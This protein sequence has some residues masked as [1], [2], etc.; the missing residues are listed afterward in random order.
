MPARDIPD[1]SGTSLQCSYVESRRPDKPAATSTLRIRRFSV[2]HN[3]GSRTHT[4]VGVH[5][6]LK[7]GDPNGLWDSL[8]VDRASQKIDGNNPQV[9]VRALTICCDT[10][11]VCGEFSL[12][13]AD[14]AVFARRLLWADDAAAINTSPLPWTMD[15]ARNAAGS[16]AGDS[17]ANGRKAGALRIFLKQGPA[18]GPARPRLIAAGGRGQDPGAGQD[19]TD[20]GWMNAY[21]KYPF[22]IRDS[23]MSTSKRTVDFSPVAVFVEYEWRWAAS[24]VWGPGT[25]GEKRFPADGTHALAP[26]KPG[27]GGDGGGLTTNQSGLPALFYNP[28]GAAG[29]QERNYRGGSAGQPAECAHYNV[30]LWENLFGTDNASFE[31]NLTE[32]RTAQKGNDAT[33]PGA[34]RALGATP[35]PTVLVMPNGWL[36]PLGLQATLEFARDLFLAGARDDVAALLADYAEGLAGEAPANGAWDTAPASQWTAAQSEVAAML[37]RLA[38]QLDY[39]GHPAGYTPLLSLPGAI[40]LYADETRRAL[41]MMLV[42]RWVSDASRDAKESADSL[43][44]ALD[45]TIADS[46]A[47]TEQVVAGE[48]RIDQVRSLIN[49][50]EK[51]LNDLSNR[52]VVLRNDL[53]VKVI[54]DKERQKAIKFSIKMAGALCQVIPVGQPALGTVGSLASVAADFVGGDP[55]DVPDTVSKMGGVLKKANEAAEK[56]KEASKKAAEKKDAP[57]A[58]NAAGAKEQSSAWATVGK[59]LGPALEITAGALKSLQVPKSEIDA[60]L[61]RLESEDAEW[62]RMTREIRKLNEKKAALFGNLVDAIQM[63]GEGFARLAGNSGTIVALWQQREKSLGR[64]DPEAVMAVQ[65]LGQRS[66]LTLQKYL[67]LMVKAYESTLL[68]PL[69]VDWNL[70]AVTE[71]IDA[72]LKPGTP[73]DAAFIKAQGDVLDTLFQQNLS[74]VRSQLLDNFDM[75]E[76]TQ[77][78]RL[79]L[80]AAQTP[81]ILETLGQLGQVVIDPQQHGLVLPNQ[82]LARLGGVNLVRL[83]FD[84]AGPKVADDVNVLIGLVPAPFGTM[85]RAEGIYRVTS[86]AP[87][88]W[89]WTCFGAN[90]IRPA[91]P[92]ATASD[93]LDFILGDGSERIRQRVALPPVWSDFT[94]SLQFSPPLPPEA[95]PRITQLMFELSIDSSPAPD[96]QRVLAIRERG[97]A[98]GA[99]TA[100][101]ADL[102]GRSSGFGSLIRIYNKGDKVTV[103]VPQYAGGAA[104]EHWEVIGARANGGAQLSFPVEDHVLAV[105][106]WAPMAEREAAPVVLSR[107][108]DSATLAVIA[109][110]HRDEETRHELRSVRMVRAPSPPPAARAIRAEPA[111]DAS[112]IGIIP[113]HGEPDVVE[114]PAGGWLL[115]NYRGVVGWVAGEPA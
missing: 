115:V 63:V 14:V 100:C 4:V 10:L 11:E 87:V 8:N 90:D 73:C 32:K 60:E 71:K 103:S 33:A 30:K 101:S 16:T 114:Q 67:Y 18:A 6:V 113:P 25:L 81:G 42:T 48:A 99:V 76:R 106:C 13:E 64:I 28:G 36:H 83:V 35:A 80:S 7:K 26:G 57:A 94:L 15:K 45:A 79:G 78:L 97:D 92:S 66:R 3:D 58:K 102:G 51:D 12:P 110:E 91:Q 54:N 82:Q 29:K 107:V 84:P 112:V 70:T 75:R 46:K 53:L 43:T 44:E 105:S 108:I 34:D 56:A 98:G 22:S 61:A 77:V 20:G 55:D 95:R 24:R 86:D 2:Q 104:F 68:K 59:G 17:G 5:V 31:L 19:G 89:S 1:L 88:R 62:N 38:G 72:L 49:S 69:E 85:R 111:S 74:A 21:A 50:L 52:L 40:K 23:G 27:S 65:Q 47:A 41:R 37:Q 9:A 93:V 96:F 39:F 109:K